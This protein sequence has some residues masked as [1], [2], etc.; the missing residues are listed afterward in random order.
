MS[1]I[2]P[3]ENSASAQGAG[4]AAE[5][6]TPAADPPRQAARFPDRAMTVLSLIDRGAVVLFFAA[7]TV[8]KAYLL[9][10]FGPQ[11]AGDTIGYRSFA[12]Q[13][14]SGGIW[15]TVPD[16]TTQWQP[17]SAF[18]MIGYPL[19]LAGSQV[20]AGEG[21]AWPLAILQSAVS[22]A[23][24][25]VLYLTAR[26]LSGLRLVGLLAALLY[27]MSQVLLFDL[28][29]LT[30][31]FHTSLVVIVVCELARMHFLQMTP[32]PMR[33]LLLGALLACALLLREFQFYL[34]VLYLPPLLAYVL[35]ATHRAVRRTV[36]IAAFAG[37]FLATAASYQMWNKLRT[38]HAFMTTG[39]QTAAIWALAK[40]AEDGAP[41]FASKA[42]V[43][44]VIAEETLKTYKF[45]EVAEIN[46]AL[47]EK[48]GLNAIQ[49]AS[50]ARNAFLRAVR[51]YPQT[52]AKRLTSNVMTASWLLR[53]GFVPLLDF[54]GKTDTCFGDQPPTGVEARLCRLQASSYSPSF[55]AFFV[56]AVLAPAHLIALA[57]LGVA[58]PR[59][60]QIAIGLWVIGIGYISLY[61]M[62]HMELRYVLPAIAMMLASFALYLGWL[63][64]CGRAIATAA[65]D[66]IGSR[67]L[68]R[69]GGPQPSDPSSAGHER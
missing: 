25:W 11:L 9:V 32:T 19:L 12:D 10:R 63:V 2:E 54:V 60:A 39:A 17:I 51:T 45:S 68:P 55:N 49:I 26:D 21:W 46:Q 37:P 24:T 41:V 57:V 66:R 6:R 22:I 64:D 67:R 23:A 33:M 40:L 29:V 48:H 69:A 44:D 50:I 58:I 7:L 42:T 35:A 43:L 1:V 38:D 16:L 15:T 30:D 31:S 28:F 36:L 56:F 8:A 27:A 65:R 34:F 18:R 61:A 4:D 5:S 14:L 53:P 59:R 3:T 62:I 47:F 20:V 52:V 13:I